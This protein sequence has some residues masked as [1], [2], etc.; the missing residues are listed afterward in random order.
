MQLKHRPMKQS[1]LTACFLLC[2][3]LPVLSRA[4]SEKEMSAIANF[5]LAE[6]SYDNKEYSKALTY[7]E[8]AKKSVGNKPKLLF[9]QIMIEQERISDASSMQSLLD[10]IGAFEKANGIDDFSKDKKMLVAKNKVL[11]KEKLS[12]HLAQEE[13]QKQ[14]QLALEKKQKAGNDNFERF[15]L[16]SLPFG[17]TIEEFQKQYPHILP[18]NIKKGKSLSE[19]VE[20]EVYYPKTIFF[21]YD[22][23]G[24]NLPFN[25]STGN[26]VYD[27]S[28]YALIVKDNK[29]VGFK[30]TLFYYNSKGQG[31]LSWNDALLKKFS[32]Y[33]Q[34]LELFASPPTEHNNVD[35]WY[36]R[37]DGKNLKSVKLLADTHKAPNGNKWKCSL[38]IS[39]VS[40]SK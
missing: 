34:F 9:L 31:N 39:V 37:K 7:L 28:I 13:K 22:D 17:L 38:T 2:I 14:E 30:Q 24:F 25:A 35:Y 18:G 6:E 36:W 27:T 33:Q 29:V 16:N 15:T 32:V 20:V 23:K 12:Q 10:L 4:Q 19:G 1:F 11:L 3:L 8:E 5:Q 26:P 40:F 21:E